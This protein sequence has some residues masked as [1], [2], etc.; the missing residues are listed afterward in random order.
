[1]RRYELVRF[2]VGCPRCGA[3]PDERCITQDEWRFPRSNHPERNARY[4]QVAAQARGSAAS[5]DSQQTETES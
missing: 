4:K 1:M 3:K 5:R 2:Y